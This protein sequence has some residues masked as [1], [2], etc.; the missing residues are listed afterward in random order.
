M[1]VSFWCKNASFKM[2]AEA[3]IQL[4]L[5]FQNGVQLSFVVYFLLSLIHPPDSLLNLVG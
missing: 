4:Y 1:L 2:T 3:E 5:Q